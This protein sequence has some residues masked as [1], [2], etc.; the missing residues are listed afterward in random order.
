MEKREAKRILLEI[1]TAVEN[2][3]GDC[4]RCPFKYTAKRGGVKAVCPFGECVELLDVDI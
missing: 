3:G 4:S 1:V 2:I